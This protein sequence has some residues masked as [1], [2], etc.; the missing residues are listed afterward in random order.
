MKEGWEQLDEQ[1]L[2][3][4]YFFDRQKECWVCLDCLKEFDRQEIFA[5]DGKF[6]TA[7]KAV[8]LHQKKE[9]PDR[10][11]KIL[12]EE[13]KLLSLTEKQ[14]QLLER[15]AAGMT[16]AQIAKEFGVSAST[17]RHQ[18]FVFRERAK[19]AKLYL[20]VWQMVQQGREQLDRGEE[21][22]EIHGGATMVDARYEIT[23]QEKQKILSTVFASMQPLR[24]KTFP[25]KEK[26]KVVILRTIAKEFEEGIRYSE[27]QVNEI[28]KDIYPDY[29]TL[30][31]YLIEYGYLE[32]TRDGSAYWKK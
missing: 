6:Y 2:A 22:I 23:Q 14:E 4:G 26:K 13:K 11:H 29:V 27:V 9:H 18:R 20:A 24:L 32:R 10:L 3:Q 1:Q 30:R 16:D 19:S 15:F 21:L 25:P 12:E 5:F 7:Q 31:R 28:L 17:V 8:Q